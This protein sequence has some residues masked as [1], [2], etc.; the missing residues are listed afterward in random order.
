MDESS[1]ES[2]ILYETEE[3]QDPAAGLLRKRHDGFAFKWGSNISLI[4]E[5]NRAYGS[6]ATRHTGMDRTTVASKIS[7][8][9]ELTRAYCVCAAWHTGMDRVKTQ[10]HVPHQHKTFG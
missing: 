3:N 6:R 2:K 1:C 4:L 5:L 9:L 10:Q 8:I 7:L